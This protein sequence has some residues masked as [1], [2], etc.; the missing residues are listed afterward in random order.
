MTPSVNK[1]TKTVVRVKKQTPTVLHLQVKNDILLKSL[2]LLGRFF[3]F[4]FVVAKIDSSNAEMS[5][6]S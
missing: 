6:R 5:L 2:I 4:S 3:S 1:V